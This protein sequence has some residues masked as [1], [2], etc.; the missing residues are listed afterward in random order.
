MQPSRSGATPGPTV[1]VWMEEDVLIVLRVLL[2]FLTPWKALLFRGYYVQGD[3]FCP[4][5][6]RFIMNPRTKKLTVMAMLVAISIVLVYL[7]HFPIFPAAAFLEY[8]PAD[9]P[10]LVGAF[11]YG[12]ITGI[13]LTAA[14][15]LIQ[16][17]TVSAQSG[18]YGIIMHF[19]ATS[20]LVVVSS[21]IYRVR[22]TR[23]GAVT[24][25]VCGSISMGLIMMAANHLVT[26]YF[27]GA[28]VEVVD[29]ML[30]PVILPFNLA[31]AGINSVVTFVVYKTV[32]R[33]IIHSEAK[34]QP[35][36]A[37]DKI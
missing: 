3:L 32:S 25:L 23:T 5:K 15:C 21:T 22:H 26:P 33:H 6:E 14:A 16:G 35:K 18:W 28:P 37:E 13:L 11:A 8:D 7:I 29:A 20:T 24:G 4:R 19:I 12:P 1:T 36:R 34:P 10:I 2:Y 9:I 27:M 31:K 17:L 30:L